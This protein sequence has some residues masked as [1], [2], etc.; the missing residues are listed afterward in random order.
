MLP[1]MSQNCQYFV[2]S[3]LNA[4]VIVLYSLADLGGLSPA[5]SGRGYENL[6]RKT[7]ELQKI[8]RMGRRA[9]DGW[10][11]LSQCFS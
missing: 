6:C 2:K 9:S 7:T 11:W 10:H 8:D 5:R 1:E 3:R 4:I